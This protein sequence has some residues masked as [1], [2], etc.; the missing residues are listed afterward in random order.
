[1]FGRRTGRGHRQRTG[2]QSVTVVME[3]LEPRALL[4]AVAGFNPQQIR[5]AYGFDD[6][7]LGDGTVAADGRGQTIAIIDAFNHP[8]IASDV[9]VFSQQF[10]L[11]AATLTVVNQTGGSRLP[12][13]D[14]G[15]AGEI[16]LDVEWAHAIAP[17][18]GILLVEADSPETADLMAA[19]DTARHA[20]GVSAVS[21]S[22]GGSEFFS[23]RGDEST[24]QLALDRTFTTPAGHGGVTFVASAGDS[25][26]SGGVQWPAS[27]PNVVAVGGTSLAKSTSNAR[28]WVESVWG[29]VSNANGGAGSGCSKYSA[30][31]S[32]QK[33]T[34][35]AKRTVADVS[36][37]ADPN[38]GVAVYDTYN[39]SGWL[40]FGG[41]S[42]SAPV[43]ASIYALAGNGAGINS[44][45]F[46]YAHA[47]SLND[48]TSGN[49]GSCSVSYLCTAVAGYDGPTGLGTPI[50]TAAF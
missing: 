33:D 46:A 16:A 39:E 26:T 12:R 11:P 15:W 7:L 2:E 18:A 17:A 48:V 25:G 14:A 3:G 47:T 24:S 34:G 4:A 45:A 40:V 21:M 50:G 20:P 44:P 41:T 9:N 29:S 36:A 35:C 19:V 37:V 49:N 32:W 8:N 6:I 28:G 38:T 23:F 5:A 1:M 10:G 43:I 13:T 22:W 42:V 30:K 31:P 27:S